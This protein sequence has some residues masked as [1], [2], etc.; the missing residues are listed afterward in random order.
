MPKEYIRT[1]AG[2]TPEQRKALAVSSHVCMSAGAGTGKT[3][4]LAAR[5]MAALEEAAAETGATRLNPDEAAGHA[6]RS[7]V[8]VTFTTAAA[9]ELKERVKRAIEERAADGSPFWTSAL[10]RMPEARIGTIHSLCLSILRSDPLAAG[11]PLAFEILQADRSEDLRKEAAAR[12]VSRWGPADR[13]DL[14][15]A[16]R[17]LRSRKA[18]VETLAS[19][20]AARHMA[21]A[22]VETC[23]R[24][25]AGG[26]IDETAVKLAMRE[27]C[28]LCSNDVES[29]LGDPAFR[30]AIE[31]L[32]GLDASSF[33]DKE[34][35]TAVLVANLSG[36]A[37][38]L[39]RILRCARTTADGT[40]R[41][42]QPDRIP[43]QSSLPRPDQ[44]SSGGAVC[45]PGSRSHLGAAG[46]VVASIPDG[47]AGETTGVQEFATAIG[48]LA[49][50]F[51]NSLTER[52]RILERLPGNANSEWKQAGVDKE[53]FKKHYTALGEA[54][55]RIWPAP[56]LV[57]GAADPTGAAVSTAALTRLYMLARTEYDALKEGACD[58]DDLLRLTRD[59]LTRDERIRQAASCR[60]IM[61]DEFQD[62]DPVQWEILAMLAGLEAYSKPAGVELR[63]QG[64]SLSPPEDSGQALRDAHLGAA[65]GSPARGQSSPAAD[66][67][68][69]ARTSARVMLVGDEKQ[70][71]F[72]FRNAD[73]T[74]FAA[75]R[76]QLR[77]AAEA[78]Y[79]AGTAGA[80]GA[81]EKGSSI[82]A[83]LTVNFR[84]LP[85]VV[86]TINRMFERIFAPAEG[87]ASHRPYEARSQPL[88]P[89]CRAATG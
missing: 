79:I 39:I 33:P 68:S 49:E 89:G 86:E 8:A 47:K 22:W 41:H 16:G 58:F 62:T 40:Y 72:R 32:A 56:L 66:S 9:T 50:V 46:S 12:V 6:V 57:M 3:R 29:L 35:K 1:D 71:I 85:K 15:E 37:R 78:E 24:A 83:K 11:L 28:R 27:R 84:S 67:T 53:E 2:L 20:L 31:Y 17:D 10:L 44:N 52:F 25:A 45:C 77:R 38:Q 55:R 61:V 82:E 5:Y 51:Y 7:I 60:H 18:L 4:A 70:S 43:G 13:K 23:E 80:A 69:R 76:E 54:V 59:L 63:A 48:A 14:L 26:K 64:C 73:V 81:A 30:R 74:V 19:L 88:S 42:A 87:G 34:S 75:A 21:D 65:P 36:P